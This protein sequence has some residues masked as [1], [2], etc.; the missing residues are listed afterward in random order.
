MSK[1]RR[2]YRT[3]ALLGPYERQVAVRG[4]AERSRS[5]RARS[6]RGRSQRRPISIPAVRI[7]W[8]LMIPLL[9]LVG[10]AVWVVMADSWYLMW[11]D[12]TVSGLSYPEME[13][14]VKETSDLLGYHRLHLNPREA[15]PLLEAALPHV[16]SVEARCGLFPTTCEIRI[17]ERVPVLAWIE[18]TTAYWIDD[19]GTAF[20]ALLDRPDLPVIRGTLPEPDSPYPL[21]A[22]LT[23]ITTLADFGVPLD[24]LGCSRE[25]GLVWTD[26]EGRQVA[27]GAGTGMA[28]RWQAYQ[29]MAG[30]FAETGVSVQELDVR[31]PAGITYKIGRSW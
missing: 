4:R 22:I 28:E 7:P 29:L 27:F 30:H 9:A 26:P 6:A 18:G 14:M 2:Y 31:F 10:V 19:T 3:A 25:R 20:P 24:E 12:L 13:Q 21:A 11:D 1:K 8:K 23:G 5:K 15:E 17:Q 16:A